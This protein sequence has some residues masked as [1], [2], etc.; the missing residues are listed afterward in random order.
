MVKK[1]D[2]TINKDNKQGSSSFNKDKSKA[3]NKNRDVVNGNVV[4]N[5]TA[6][7]PKAIFNLTTSLQVAKATEHATTRT[8][9]ISNYSRHKP[10]APRPKREY[11]PLGEPLDVIFKT[12]VKN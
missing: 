12:L 2:L 11:T 9:Q 3:T 5:L 4:D 10:W 8:K 6:K 1:G 7:P